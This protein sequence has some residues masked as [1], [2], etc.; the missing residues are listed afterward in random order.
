MWTGHMTPSPREFNSLD[1]PWYNHNSSL[2]GML[3]IRSPQHLRA[4][5]VPRCFRSTYNDRGIADIFYFSLTS[6]DIDLFTILTRNVDVQLLTQMPYGRATKTSRS[7]LP[8]E[9]LHGRPCEFLPLQVRWCWIGILCTGE[10][11]V[12]CIWGI[13]ITIPLSW[14]WQVLS[15]VHTHNMQVIF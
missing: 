12:R 4:Y 6:E 10:C 14:L 1:C 5:A 15:L 2:A 13:I 11:R 9:Q 7:Q 8:G 3:L